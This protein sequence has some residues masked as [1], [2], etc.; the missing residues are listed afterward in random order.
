MAQVVIDDHVFDSVKRNPVKGMNRTTDGGFTVIDTL[1]GQRQIKTARNLDNRTLVIVAYQ[2]DGMAEADALAEMAKKQE[3]VIIT[4]GQGASW[5]RWTIQKVA[6]KYDRVLELG[7][8]QVIVNTLSLL[9][10][11]QDDHIS[12]SSS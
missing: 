7:I 8:A 2:G 4:D 9:E 11:R 6:S 1:D 3:P 12:I 10:Y 5:G